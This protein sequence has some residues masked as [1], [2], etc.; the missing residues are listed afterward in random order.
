MS[1]HISKDGTLHGHRHENLRSSIPL[2]FN[3]TNVKDYDND[4][5]LAFY[6]EGLLA[7]YP[8]I[9]TVSSIYFDCCSQFSIRKQQF[10]ALNGLPR[11]FIA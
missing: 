4:I 1:C 5:I 8:A 2:V 10:H 11:T 3:I 9:A 6:C 7:V